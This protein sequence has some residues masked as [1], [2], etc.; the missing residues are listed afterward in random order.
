VTATTSAR[1]ILVVDDNRD[2][3]ESLA[4]LL[5]IDGHDTRLAYDGLDAVAAAEQFKPDLVLLD[6]GLPKLNGYEAARRMRQTAWGKAMVVVAL[7]GWG[8]QEDRNKSSQAGFDEHLV[9]PVDHDKL[10]ALLTDL[11]AL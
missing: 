4:A 3:A 9:K 11:P 8:Q 1:R 6:I 10:R 2:A 7:T 5:Q